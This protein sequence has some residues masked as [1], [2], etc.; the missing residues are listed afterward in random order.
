MWMLQGT[1]ETSSPT[2]TRLSR[3]VLLSLST[4]FLQ[5]LPQE[6]KLW[7][8]LRADALML[9]GADPDTTMLLRKPCYGQPDAPRRWFLEAVRRLRELGLRQHLMDPCTCLVYSQDF[10]AKFGKGIAERPLDSSGLVGV[11]CLMLTTFLA[12]V[13]KHLCSTPRSLRP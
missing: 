10:E 4:A 5:G 11:I 6:R 3:N 2:I 1:L 12:P 13:M 7:V 9:L 8:K